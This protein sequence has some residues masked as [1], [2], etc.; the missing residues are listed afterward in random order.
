MN[1][2]AQRGF[3]TTADSTTWTSFLAD[4]GTVVST[5]D[6]TGVGADG[7]TIKYGR[8]VGAFQLFGNVGD[9][10]ASDDPTMGSNTQGNENLSIGRGTQN[11]EVVGGTTE[12]GLPNDTWGAL[13]RGSALQ[14]TASTVPLTT[15]VFVLMRVDH[16]AGLSTA[17]TTDD[18][19]DDVAYI[20]INPPS[21]TVEPALGTQ[22]LTINPNSFSGP[23]QSQGNNDRDYNFN[24]I[25]IFGGNLNTTP[26]I[27][28]SSV[29]VDEFRIGE[30][31]AD[32]TPNVPEPGSAA[33]AAIGLMALAARRRK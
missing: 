6:Y 2:A 13:N 9:N 19:L 28:Y 11:S 12:L 18:D 22:T 5:G 26:G 32:V 29:I 17:L 4:L 10:I 7:G 15:Q 3:S 1:F 21:L 33:L 30:T 25:R 20:W 14:T 16:K 23:P 31:F 24:R 8:G 27:G